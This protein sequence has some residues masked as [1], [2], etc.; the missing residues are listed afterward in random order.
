MELS[1]MSL[2]AWK[3]S[4]C[5]HDEVTDLLNQLSYQVFLHI[6]NK[7]KIIKYDIYDMESINAFHTF[8]FY[9]ICNIFKIISYF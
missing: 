8:I 4:K 3:W 5:G 6:I 9:F 7:S 2:H 1:I